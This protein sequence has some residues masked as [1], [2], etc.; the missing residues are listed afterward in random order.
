MMYGLRSGR[1]QDTVPHTEKQGEDKVSSSPYPYAR[2][3]S[4]SGPG[5]LVKQEPSDTL[6]INNHLSPYFTQ[7]PSPV[8]GSGTFGSLRLQEEHTHNQ[9]TH[10]Q[11]RQVDGRDCGLEDVEDLVNFD[12]GYVISSKLSQLV[13]SGAYSYQTT[14]PPP[15]PVHSR[16]PYSLNS[17]CIKPDP[18]SINHPTTL[19]R[20]HSYFT[21]SQPDTQLPG[22]VRIKSEPSTSIN[23]CSESLTD[24]TPSS[25]RT[26]CMHVSNITGPTSLKVKVE[27][28]ANTDCVSVKQDPDQ[29]RVKVEP[30]T[31][32]G[33]VSVKQD[34][35]QPSSPKKYWHPSVYY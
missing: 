9:T 7:D 32:T 24:T 11:F 14:P 21:T 12:A 19:N 10:D 23:H 17:V 34:P 15:R 5:V 29:L 33:C 8:Q 18:D 2:K 1:L 6:F 22:Q 30:G 13:A 20:T 26:S 3:H 16:N 27:P 31:K 4:N 35:D 28:G 25:S